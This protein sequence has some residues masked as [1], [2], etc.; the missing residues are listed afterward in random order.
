MFAKNILAIL[1]GIKAREEGR[2]A[3]RNPAPPPGL[4][5]PRPARP[6]PQPTVYNR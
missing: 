6:A 1:Q 2:A 4:E 3:V 5:P